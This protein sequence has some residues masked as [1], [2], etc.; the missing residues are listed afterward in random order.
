MWSKL[1]DEAPDLGQTLVDWRPSD[2]SVSHRVFCRCCMML[3]VSG[4]GREGVPV[5]NIRSFQYS[6][7]IALRLCRPCHASSFL[8]AASIWTRRP[9]IAQEAW[10]GLTTGA[11]AL[12][13]PPPDDSPGF[14]GVAVLS[15]GRCWAAFTLDPA[16][17]QRAIRQPDK[18][19]PPFFGTCAALSPVGRRLSRLKPLAVQLCLRLSN[20]C[21]NP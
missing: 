11:W 7:C 2:M 16:H 21:T 3:A 13:P 9:C 15:D 5:H 1:F 18:A 6:A 14:R 19:N 20:P 8:Q 4:F 12:P 10:S 17:M